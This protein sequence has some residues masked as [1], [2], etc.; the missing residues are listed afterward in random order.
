MIRQTV[1]T[2]FFTPN[3]SPNNAARLGRLPFPCKICD[4]MPSETHRQN[5]Q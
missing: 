3:I 5:P 1:A 2:V 4:T